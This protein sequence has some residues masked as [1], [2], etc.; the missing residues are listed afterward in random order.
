MSENVDFSSFPNTPSIP[1]KLA[2]I[3]A[4]ISESENFI[5]KNQLKK[6]HESLETIRVKL[7]ELR[8]ENGIKNI[9]DDMLLFHNSMEKLVESKVKDE[10]LIQ[11]LEALIIPF[12]NYNT[13][14]PDYKLLLENL[15]NILTDLK[16]KN[17]KAYSKLLETLKPA[18]IQIYLQ[19]W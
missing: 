14:N 12:K 10:L 16:N 2:E 7:M 5:Q 9:S 8:L 19:F 6:A 18:F 4:I 11:E 3:E 15:S 1:S 17:W 13:N